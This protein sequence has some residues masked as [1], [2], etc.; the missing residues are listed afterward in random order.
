[1]KAIYHEKK[2]CGA[3]YEIEHTGLGVPYLE[4][5]GCGHKVDDWVRWAEDYSKY[6]EEKERWENKRD[7]LVCLLG[8]FVSLYKANYGIDFSFSLNERGLFRSAEA[9]QIRKLYHSFDG[10]AA[11]AAA[12]IRWVFAKKV[13]ERKRKITSL[14]F[15]NVPATLNEFKQQKKKAGQIGRSTM[16]PPKMSDWLKQN[17]PDIPLQDFGDLRNLLQHVKKDRIEKTKII[18][19]LIDKL[20][21]AKMVSDD[22]EIAGWSE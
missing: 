16:L 3:K 11:L 12:Y 7:H 4:C 5:S 21:K 22:L 2:D 15:L 6:W 1:M 9:N 14:G 20:Q 17:L 18:G 10:D 13:V 8:L 19:V